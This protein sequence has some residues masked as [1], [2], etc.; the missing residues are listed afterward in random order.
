L[1]ENNGCNEAAVQAIKAVKW[2]PAFQKEDKPVAVWVSVPVKFKLSQEEKEGLLVPG[3]NIAAEALKQ[4]I[5]STDDLEKL[6]YDTPPEPVGGYRELFKN[7]RFPVIARKTGIEGTVTIY[8]KVDETGKVVDT[9]IKESIGKAGLDEA[10]IGAIRSVK[11]HPAYLKG[12]AVEAWLAVPIQFKLTDGSFPIQYKISGDKLGDL[13]KQIIRSQKLYIDGDHE[14]AFKIWNELRADPN[15]SRSEKESLEKIIKFTKNIDHNDKA[16]QEKEKLS[17]SIQFVPYDVPPNPVGGFAAIQKKL[18][19]PEIARQAGVEGTVI[20]YAKVS[21]DGKIIDT[22]I[23]KPLVNSGC[24]E[25]AI[26][27][28]KSVEWKPALQR[29]K[30][31]TVW[32]SVPVK[33]KLK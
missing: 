15:L 7:I 22:R 19:Y 32:V 26:Q 4:S 9:R 13:E 33:F 27:A 10:A 1:G 5:F 12:E 11:W 25:A 21:K 17:D 23:V 14:S 3:S 28:I 8:T 24:N 16:K 29:D 18:V 20:I 2:K 31:V 6:P 30:P